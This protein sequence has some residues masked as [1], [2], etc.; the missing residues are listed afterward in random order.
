MAEMTSQDMA[1]K[2]L[3]AGF[4][5]SGPSAMADGPLRSNPAASSLP[6]MSWEV[7]SAMTTSL[8][9]DG[10]GHAGLALGAADLCTGVEIR[11]VVARC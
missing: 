4:E 1:G 5:R 7:I 9:V 3:A 2:L 8:G 10:P 6:A 11:P